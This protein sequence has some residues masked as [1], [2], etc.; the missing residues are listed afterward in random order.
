MELL[1]EFEIGLR[2]HKLVVK[3][4]EDGETD[5]IYEVYT[6]SD[7]IDG[8]EKTVVIRYDVEE[9][10]KELGNIQIWEGDPDE[11]VEKIKKDFEEFPEFEISE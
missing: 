10:R 1:G 7:E 4:A 2:H 5:G 11:V 3:V 9:G 8:G 6:A